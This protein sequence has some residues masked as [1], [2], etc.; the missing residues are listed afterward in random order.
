VRFIVVDGGSSDR[1]TE[2]ISKMIFNDFLLRVL[3][4]EQ[5]VPAPEPII[6]GKDLE[7]IGVDFDRARK[8]VSAS[9]VVILL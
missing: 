5:F 3:A 2:A 1:S 7:S 6:I 9:K 4:E 8:V